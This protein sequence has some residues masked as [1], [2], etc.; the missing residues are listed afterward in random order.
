MNKQ[1]QLM[2]F[3]NQFKRVKNVKEKLDQYS[4]DDL[5]RIA[6][7]IFE[8]LVNIYIAYKK[9]SMPK[10]LVNQFK[11]I[12]SIEDKEILI[13]IIDNMLTTFLEFESFIV[14]RRF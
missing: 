9:E 3:K 6:K 12:N 1:L 5:R 4:V 13:P 8:S 11:R 14:R 10:Y 7:N 2:E